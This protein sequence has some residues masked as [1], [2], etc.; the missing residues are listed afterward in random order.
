MTGL[1]TLAMMF[2]IIIGVALT[3]TI[4]IIARLL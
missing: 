2:G 1:D 4:T 3:L